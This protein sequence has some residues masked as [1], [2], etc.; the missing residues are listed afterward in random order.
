MDSQTVETMAALDA[1]DEYMSMNEEHGAETQ[2]QGETQSQTQPTQAIQTVFTT[3]KRLKSKVW[4]EFIPVVGVEADGKRRGRCVHCSKKL[5]IEPSQGTSALKR[6]LESCSK[7]PLGQSTDSEYDHKVDREMVS[8]IIIFHDLPFRYVEYPKFRARDKYLNPNCQP[9]C[10]QTAGSDVFRRYEIEMEKL[11]K[12]FADFKGKVCFTADM[13]TARSTMKGYICITA[14]YVDENW[15]LCNKILAFCDMNPPHTG[16]ELACKVLNCLI[17]YGLE[18]NV[19]FLTL[20]N[21]K[22]NDSMQK[23]LQHRL[24]MISGNGL[25]CGGKFFHVRCCAHIL[26]LIVQ[27]G[28]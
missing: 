19:F 10:R 23:I 6:H 15:I 1:E 11:K 28:L 14:H 26:N 25:L 21:A 5:I 12:V 3:N 4:K 2:G 7:R 13:W 8:E 24:Q 27:E 18:K 17:E 9:I 20:D 16:E 22:S